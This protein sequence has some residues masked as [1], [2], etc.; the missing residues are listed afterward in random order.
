M[1]R[2]RDGVLERSKTNPNAPSPSLGGGGARELAHGT[3]PR[4]SLGASVCPKCDIVKLV[5]ND[6]SRA[7]FPKA[8][9]RDFSI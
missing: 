4:R 1:G 7:K 8:S 2:P 6:Y 3:T 9:P 5:A